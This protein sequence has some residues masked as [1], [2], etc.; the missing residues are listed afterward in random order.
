MQK[1]EEARLLRRRLRELGAERAQ[2]RRR[3][4]EIRR[5]NPDTVIEKCYTRFLEESAPEM[6]ALRDRL[7]ELT[8]KRW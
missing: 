7:Q 5:R 2:D 3:L 6:K 4:A 8:G 1:S